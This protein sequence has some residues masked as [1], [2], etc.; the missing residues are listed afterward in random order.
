MPTIDLAPILHAVRQ[1][2]ALCQRVQQT[3]LD[4]SEKAGHEPVTIAD[5]GSQAI[6]C[7]A[8]SRAFPDDAVLA[9]EHGSQFLEVVAE[10]QR[11][12]ITRMVSEVLGETVSE[13]DIVGWLDYGQGR[14]ARCTWVIDPI[15]GTQGFLAR[16]RYAIAVGLL[17]NG[18]PVGAVLGSPAY[19]TADGRGLL[20]YALDGEA[21]AES[22]SGGTARRIRVSD[23]T[24]VR[25]VESVEVLHSDPALT[26]RVL[27]A[28]GLAEAQVFE[29]D[30]MDKYAMVACGDAELYLR[31]PAVRGYR[32]KAWDHAAGTALVQAAGGVVTDLNGAP[33]DFSHGAILVN[34]QGMVVSNR[35]I[36]ERVLW[37]IEKV[38]GE[39]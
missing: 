20:F 28:A 6:L 34:N 27:A 15:D 39:G 30:S 1:S 10:P 38:M 29:V 31:I 36:H 21:C 24:E 17:E 33:L 11:E 26:A 18:Q 25:V 14:Q 9:E 4:R 22:L 8:I 35:R 2:A 32:H 16:R 19:P 7:R 12:Q 3:H 37:G 13:A 23:R 5:Y